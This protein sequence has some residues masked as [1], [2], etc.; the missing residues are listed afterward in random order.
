MRGKA[1]TLSLVQSGAL[2]EGNVGGSSWDYIYEAS[3]V[4]HPGFDIGDRVQLPDGRVFRYAKSGAACWSGR[5]CKFGNEI[6]AVGIDYK[7]LTE[8]AP[9]GQD[10]VKTLAIVT[11]T[12]DDLRGGHALFKLINTSNDSA[13]QQRLITGNSA[14]A[15][16]VEMTVYLDAGLSA[17]LTTLSYIVAMPSPWS[18]LRHGV[19]PGND[20]KRSHAGVPAVYVDAADK[21]FWCQTWGEVWVAPDGECGTTAHGRGLVWRYDGSVQ[22]HHATTAMDGAQQQLA[23]FCLDA[24]LAANGMTKMMLQV[25][26]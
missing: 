6:P 26:P 20:D 4:K 10:W 24:N 5:G 11:H 9:R 18:N 23:G 19:H 22:L 15:I 13:I 8:N 1:K 14:A 3:T 2:V 21:Y 25:C 12:A 7:V 17:A 16:G